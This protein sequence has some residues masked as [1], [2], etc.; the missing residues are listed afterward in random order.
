MTT[1]GK[2]SKAEFNRQ[3][4]AASYYFKQVRRRDIGPWYISGEGNS[5][6]VVK[7]PKNPFRVIVHNSVR[8]TVDQD[9]GVHG[10]SISH[11]RG[12][13]GLMGVAAGV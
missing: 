5:S 1:Q 13:Q 10:F 7:E 6:D 3:G 11:S 8:H 2:M 4:R 9:L 12:D